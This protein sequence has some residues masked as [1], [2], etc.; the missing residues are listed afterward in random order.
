MSAS[1]P[2]AARLTHHSEFKRV[3]EAPE[4]KSSDRCFTVLGRSSLSNN[5]QIRLGL[6]VAK[7]QVGKA[8]ERNRIKRLVRESFRLLPDSKSCDVVVIVRNYA[9]NAENKFLF[10]SL[11]RHWQRIFA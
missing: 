11:N 10:R 8:H 7:R 2:R 4:Y 9:Q 5:N 3:F 1:F 6:V